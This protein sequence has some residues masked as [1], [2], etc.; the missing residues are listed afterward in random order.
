MSIS[1]R[2]P[3]PP[4]RHFFIKLLLHAGIAG[5]MVFA[6]LSIG[7]VGYHFTEGIPW[8][9]AY[10][11]ASMILTGMGPVNVLATDAGKLFAIV[12]SLFSGVVFLGASA[13]LVAP[14][15]HRFL[16]RFHLDTAE[17]GEA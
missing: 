12:Y 6:A 17:D 16:H 14:V 10:L 5:A 7:A 13:V 9:D 1:P 3:L 15:A 4:R 2:K 8:L 11:N